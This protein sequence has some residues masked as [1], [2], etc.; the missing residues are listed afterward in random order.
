M[1]AVICTRK[2]TF[3]QFPGNSRLMVLVSA[4]KSF[5]GIPIPSISDPSML[6][7]H[8]DTA[9]GPIGS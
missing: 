5:G 6:Q 3:K 1:T 9:K 7:Q 4:P 8:R 2:I